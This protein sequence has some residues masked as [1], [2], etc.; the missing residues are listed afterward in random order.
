MIEDKREATEPNAELRQAA[1]GLWEMYVA[2]SKEGFTDK[3]AL[4]IIGQMLAASRS[5]GGDG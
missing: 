5:E 3:Q 1:A 2:L 4:A